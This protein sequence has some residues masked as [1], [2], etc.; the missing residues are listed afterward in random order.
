MRKAGQQVPS[1]EW[2]RPADQTNKILSMIDQGRWTNYTPMMAK[3]KIQQKLFKAI[4]D[5]GAAISAVSAE[6]Y[7]KLHREDGI[8]LLPWGNRV[9]G[10]DN[11]RLITL[12]M[13]KAKVQL[14][15]REKELQLLVIQNCAQELS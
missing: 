3:V 10:A 14:G 13:I 8:G 11:Q 5:T 9:T 1:K 4:V 6:I 15:E 7:Y 2:Y 12:G